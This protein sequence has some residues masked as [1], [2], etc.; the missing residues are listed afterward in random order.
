M[1]EAIITLSDAE[2]EKLGFGDLVSHVRNAGIRDIQMLE[3]EGYTCAP[4][5]EVEDRLDGTLLD[6]LDCV[7]E[8]ELL[9][10]KV[11]SFVYLFELT[12]TGLPEE[13]AT[14]YEQVIGT[15]T[16]NINERGVLLS[17]VGSQE[18]IRDVLRHY[19]A[20]DITPNLRKLAEYQGGQ[21]TLDTLTNRQLEVIRTAYDM[22][23]YEIPREA[24]T[25]EVATRLGLEP[26]TV[27][28]HLQ[29]AERNLLTQQLPGKMD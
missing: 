11:N 10:E 24:S 6:S 14:D 21:H 18:A 19:E 7:D 16:P 1:R 8:W 15:C 12:A 13:I 5:V 29:R 28:E 22:G 4:Q 25:E 26:T 20:A 9:T 17:F 2:I 3:D 27:S 23:F